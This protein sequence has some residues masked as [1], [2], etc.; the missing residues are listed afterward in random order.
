ML[1]RNLV[2]NYIG[3]VWSAIM[4]IAFIPI[5]IKYLGI[6]SYGL[7]G[8]FGMVLSWLGLLDLGMTPT[9]SREMAR[10][11]G[12][13]HTVQSIRNLLRS[14]ECLAL[15]IAL[16]IGLGVWLS[17]DWLSSDCLRTDKLPQKLVAESFSIMGIVSALR[18]IEN[19]YRSALVG[20]QKHIVNNFIN[21][22]MSTLRGLGS[23]GI[24]IWI[25]KSIRVF[26]LW[27]GIISLITLFVLGVATYLYLPKS[28]I[29]S[30]FSFQSLKGVGSF[31]GGVIGISLLSLLLTQIDK[32][33]L[34]RLLTLTDYGYYTLASISAGALFLIIGP[35]SQVWAPKLSELQAEN[36]KQKLN[37]KY[38][39]G[40]QLITV[41]MGSLSM[42]FLFFGESILFIWT[43]NAELASK[44]SIVFRILAIGNLLNG[45]NTMP[46]LLQMAYGWTSLVTKINLIAA[47][48]IIPILLIVTP[49]FGAI[50]AALA[51][52][53]LNAGYVFIGVHFMFRK[54]L[55][56]QKWIWFRNDLLLPMLSACIVATFLSF[57]MPDKLTF[58]QL[59]IYLFMAGTF[60]FLAASFSSFYMR[61]SIFFLIQYIKKKR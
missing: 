2:A 38:H 11:T 20:L 10:Y 29:R 17:S 50:G 47:C 60:V 25:S 8:L 28:E 43:R 46:Y 37:E 12:G 40:A 6:E 59:L 23:I 39:Q 49:K 51:W 61:N 33:L 58:I 42:M 3:Q 54:I 18:F 56:D 1:K 44:T 9:L 14:I 35:I 16:I 24:L 19:V 26:F 45:L 15:L 4:S 52:L 30:R 21:I 41:V 34:S 13:A 31:A 48:L 53:L 5:Y 36:D 57:L 22:I 32:I 27:Q 7:I 55:T